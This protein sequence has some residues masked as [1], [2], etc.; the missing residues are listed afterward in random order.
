MTEGSCVQESIPDRVTGL[1][2]LPS[3]SHIVKSH[4]PRTRPL[5]IGQLNNSG[6]G[7]GGGSGSSRGGGGDAAAE[8]AFCN[9][10]EF[11]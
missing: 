1:S 5:A 9:L 3:H 8:I 11:N 4:N 10:H 2:D 7:R 6:G